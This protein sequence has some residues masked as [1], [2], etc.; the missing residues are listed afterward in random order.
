MDA[1][2]TSAHNGRQMVQMVMP[3]RK[4]S[5]A[6]KA[7]KNLCIVGKNTESNLF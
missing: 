7:D 3:I 1:K 4:Q 5:T 6:F 2:C